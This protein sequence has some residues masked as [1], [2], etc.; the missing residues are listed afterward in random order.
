MDTLTFETRAKKIANLLLE[1]EAIK[2]RP[3]QPFQWAS[4]WLSPIYCDNRLTLSYPNIRNQIKEELVSLI[5]TEF[6][7]VEAIAG[8]ATAGIPQGALVADTMELPFLYVR[9]AAKSHGMKNLIE[10]KVIPG[11]KVVVIEDLISTGSSSLV[12]VD[13][14]RD[15][16]MEVLGMAAI[17]SYGFA[18][19]IER[20][21]DANVKVAY[22]SNYDALLKEAEIRNYINNRDIQSL[23]L[24]KS[25]PENW[26]KN[27]S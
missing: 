11:K 24:W 20:F 9:T 2:L 5:K 14:L 18:L 1:I 8:V 27:K 10:G 21:K 22:L 16:G 7:Q 3:D 17:F 23:K 12:A 19:S 4:G 13:S 6:P 15:A 26:G 25:D